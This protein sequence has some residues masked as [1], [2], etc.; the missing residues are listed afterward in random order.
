M[1]PFAPGRAV[2]ALAFGF[3]RWG[4]QIGSGTFI[5]RCRE[6]RSSTISFVKRRRSAPP[7]RRGR[8]VRRRVRNLRGQTAEGGPGERQT[9]REREKEERAWQAS[10]RTKRP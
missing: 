4:G 5:R 10:G 8:S 7:K 9:G 1:I 2:A 3:A 6:R